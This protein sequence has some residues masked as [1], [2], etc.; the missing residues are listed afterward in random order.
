M[1]RNIE[2]D[3]EGVKIRGQFYVPQ[4]GRSSFPTIVMAHGFAAVKEMHINKFAEL[5]AQNGFAVLLFDNRNFG[6]S[7][8]LPRQEIQPWRQV[9]DFQ[10]AITFA[11]TLDEVDA[12]RIGVWGTSFS[13]GHALVLGAI[14]HRVKCV[15]SQVPTISGFQNAIRRG[16][17]DK[18]HLLF[19]RFV[20]DR[21]KRL[22]GG[23]PATLQVVPL[24]KDQASVF[25][26][27][28]AIEWYSAGAEIAPN[29]KNQVTLRSVEN[30]RSYEVGGYM[31]LISPTPVLMLVAE[32]D[33][34][35]PTD[36]A[37]QAYEKAL[38]PKKLVIL[39][40]GHFD[41]YVNGFKKASEEAVE[42]FT[43]NL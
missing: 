6:D 26:T 37:L 17:A 11:S 20:E 21:I 10:H 34:I 1:I 43:N 29:W 19:H 27:D 16:N 41:S 42:W 22:H 32:N 14:D 25:H 30:A 8:G 7:E 9:E 12:N 18:Q 4:D 39:K 31:E 24:E 13:G 40:G 35:T 15:V 33:Y 28:D 2:F 23:E 5:F 3:V 36:V 38:Q